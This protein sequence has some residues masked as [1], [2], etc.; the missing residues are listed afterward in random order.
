M[1][2]APSTQPK[3]GPF[4]IPALAVASHPDV[5]L[6]ARELQRSIDSLPL[7]NPVKAG[8]RL[9]H[10]ARLLTR[11]PNPGTRFGQLLNLY[12]APMQ[13]LL[14]IVRERLPGSPD[15]ALPLDQL[16]MLVVELL[17][18]LAYGHLRIANQLLAA[19]KTPTLETLFRAMS[20]LD[21]ALDIERLHYRRLAPV[22]WQLLLNIF[23]HAEYQQVGGRQIDTKQRQET[24]PDSIQGL[25]FRAL[26]VTLCDPNNQVPSEVTAWQRWTSEHA[27]LLSFTLLP[28]GAFSIPVDI[29]GQLNPLTSARSGKPGTQTRY[30]AADHFAQKLE[31]D[32]EAPAGLRHALIH[33]VKGR[34]TP[35]QR[36]SARQPRNH[37]YQLI[38]GL[39]NIHCRLEE[40]SQGAPPTRSAVSPVAAR[41]VNQ[42]RFGAA[43]QL[44]GP[45]NPPFSIGE[46]LLAEAETRPGSG[47]P[48]GF[49][50]RIRRIFSDD[51]QRIEIGAEKIQGRLI[52]VTIVGSAAERS[53]GDKLGLLQ[54]E[55][56]SGH[57]VLLASR[58]IY[59]EGDIVAV[60]GPSMR[61]NLRMRRLGG[62][63]HHTAYIDVEPIDS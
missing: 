47:A 42:S 44:Q 22:R 55:V 27:G 31:D 54:H 23:L 38:H 3:P 49:S 59:R 16:E 52:P 57:Y 12:D 35:E 53:R 7:A 61:Y 17:T 40:L 2:N 30:L 48:V 18:E 28:Q 41:Q 39:R 26:I 63:V 32:P 20:L 1:V 60:E 36:R 37:P 21:S 62:I 46:P 13:Q 43:F 14:Q 34:R 45:L 50:A 11:D 4:A 6:S 5:I 19:D 51:G 56:D 25:F 33:L 58:S 24:Q 9:L 15:S 10:Q 8:G 29:S